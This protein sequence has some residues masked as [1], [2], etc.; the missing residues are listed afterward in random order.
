MKK[1][2]VSSILVAAAIA[3]AEDAAVA[4]AESETKS[5]NADMQ[6]AQIVTS[7]MMM[8]DAF[9]NYRKERGIDAYGTPNAKGTVYFT[10]SSSVAVNVSHADFIKSRS[11]A[12][13]KAYM[14]AIAKLVMDRTGKELTKTIRE[15][16]SDDSSNAQEAPASLN[17]A[18]ATLSKKVEA[19]AE[20][21]VDQALQNMGVDPSE[22]ENKGPAAK[23]TLYCDSILKSSVKKAFGT[24]AGA[25]SVQS[26]ETRAEDGN[27]TVGV[28]LRSDAT[29][30]EVA[31]CIAKKQRPTLSNASGMTVQEALPDAAEMLTQFGVRLFFDENGEPA[32]LSFGQWGSSYRGNNTRMIE[33]ADRH[34]LKQAENLANSQLTDFI[35]STIR[36]TE[37]SLTGEE[38]VR[39]M[40]FQQDG[41][42]TQEDV[43]NFVDKW[44]NRSESIGYDTMIGRS[45]V[46]KKIL[47]HPSGHRVAVVVRCWSFGKL[48]A[49]KNV[50]D[51]GKNKKPAA[52]PIKQ[53]EPGVRKGRTYDF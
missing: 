32:L 4:I 3:F 47:I 31:R 48:D 37:E 8:E 52:K 34:A 38:E 15:L 6:A 39:R 9:E 23:K 2:L 44:Q 20:A 42:A 14:D 22:Y 19:L 24:A 45:T 12:Y 33:R 43:V 21:T 41:T 25:L 28:V 40:I 27:Y 30:T 13:Q 18:R 46:Y 11:M 35:N 5:I 36:V 26:F 49:E 7:G 51:S 53:E 50:L 1:I 10:G 29:C 17:D 16:G